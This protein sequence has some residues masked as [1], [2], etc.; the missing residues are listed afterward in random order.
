MKK[1][2]NRNYLNKAIQMPSKYHDF[3]CISKWA[4]SKKGITV[5]DASF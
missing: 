1:L 2:K 4:L 3:I 5:V